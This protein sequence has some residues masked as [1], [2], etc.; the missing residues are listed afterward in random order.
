MFLREQ[1]L[2]SGSVHGCTLLDRLFSK[3]L[4]AAH[5]RFKRLMERVLIYIGRLF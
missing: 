1:K 3:A 4:E 2:A 5:L